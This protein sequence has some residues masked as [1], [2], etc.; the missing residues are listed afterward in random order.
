MPI[1]VIQL[2]YTKLSDSKERVVMEVPIPSLQ[3]ITL[4]SCQVT[5]SDSDANL[6]TLFI[7]LPFIDNRYN[8]V[9]S[10]EMK[11][12]G[13]VT[14]GFPI[15]NNYE[16]TSTYSKPGYCFSLAD[17]IPKAFSTWGVFD[18][19]GNEYKEKD[20]TITLVFDHIKGRR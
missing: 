18:N 8:I 10:I 11:K 17:D 20:Y 3:T 14:R 15:Y 4:L 1:T 7:S 13:H 16:Q 19:D 9:S 2:K 5:L 12:D 6:H